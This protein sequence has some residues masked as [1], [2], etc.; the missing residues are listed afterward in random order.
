MNKFIYI[1]LISILFPLTQ[2]EID[3]EK[4]SVKWKG[5]KSTGSYHDGLINVKSSLLNIE[6]DNLVGGEIIIDMTTIVC[7]DIEDKGS[8]EYLVSHLKN[9]DFFSTTKH[10]EA[11]LL[12]KNVSLIKDNDYNVDA[13]LSIKGQTQPIQFTANIIIKDGIGL[14]SGKIEVDRAKYDIKYKSKSWFP[15]IGDKFINDIFELYF[16]L[17]SI[18]KK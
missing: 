6:N 7:T 14:A 16:N 11:L 5:T 9:D 8:N 10:T 2:F 4:S 18:E 3:R 17:L 13:D 12:I 15:D 1:L